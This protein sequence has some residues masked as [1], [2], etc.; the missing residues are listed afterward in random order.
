MWTARSWDPVGL[1]TGKLLLPLMAA[2]RANSQAS[3]LACHGFD[4]LGVKS[5]RRPRQHREPVAAPRC[6]EPDRAEAACGRKDNLRQQRQEAFIDRSPCTIPVHRDSAAMAETSPHLQVPN[7]VH[8]S[9]FTARSSR[10]AVRTEATLVGCLR[11]IAVGN[12]PSPWCGL[13]AGGSPG[14]WPACGHGA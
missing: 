5:G 14:E 13:A 9:G 4:R 2:G 12:R 6:T 1:A 7:P 3:A 8:D 10:Q 11:D